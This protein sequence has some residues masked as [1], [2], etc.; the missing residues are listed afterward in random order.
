[1]PQSM[2]LTFKSKGQLHGASCELNVGP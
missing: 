2:I 1:M